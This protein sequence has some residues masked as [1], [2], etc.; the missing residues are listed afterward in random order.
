MPEMPMMGGATPPAGGGA[1]PG[2]SPATA[3]GGMS[4]A[5]LQQLAQRQGGQHGPT[6]A[7][8]PVPNAGLHAAGLALI[9]K[10]VKGMEMAIPLVG[11]TS[12]A[13][14]SLLSA[15]KSLGKFIQPGESS[16]GIEKTEN[17]RMQLMQRQMGPAAAAQRASG[18]PAQAGGGAPV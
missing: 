2:A 14:Q 12:D 10:I 11:S 16:P 15:L 6:P 8:S 18:P 1:P 13:G 17:E 9:G 7:S 5:V 4:P 3:M